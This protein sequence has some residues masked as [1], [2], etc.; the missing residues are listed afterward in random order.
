MSVL[1]LSITKL[2]Q[3]CIANL[4]IVISFSTLTLRILHNKKSI[5]YSQGLRIKKLCSSPV[6]FEK[7][8]ESLRSWFCERG[9]PQ[10]VVDEQLKKVS[11]ITMHDLIGRSGKKETGVPLIVILLLLFSQP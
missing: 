1:A 11:E 7:H 4:L 2:R 10:K 6:A 5:V 9:Y 8:L 3:I